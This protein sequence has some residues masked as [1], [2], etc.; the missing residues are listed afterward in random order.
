MGAIKGIRET[1]LIPEPVVVE[2]LKSS[3]R[4]SEYD[5]IK[6]KDLKYVGMLGVGGYGRVELMH[7][8]DQQTFALK[9][10][11]KHEMVQQQQ[12]NHVFNEKEIMLACDSP[13][14]VKYGSHF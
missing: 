4:K 1:K 14:I 5:H 12:Q 13:F 9:Y 2:P 6:L 3:K 7:Y 11:K 10:L 8:K